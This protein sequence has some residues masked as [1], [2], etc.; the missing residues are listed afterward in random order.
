M[1]TLGQAD[2]TVATR[3]PPSYGRFSGWD[4]E[5]FYQAILDV[6]RNPANTANYIRSMTAV[7][8]LPGNMIFTPDILAAGWAR[9]C[10]LY[11]GQD[12]R[13]AKQYMEVFLKQAGKLETGEERQWFAVEQEWQALEKG[14]TPEMAF[15]FIP[16][17]RG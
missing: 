16:F 9:F 10:Q 12:A 2:Q 7:A 17:A 6:L 15:A 4:W 3:M 13:A 11:P 5:G 8:R 1:I 14:H